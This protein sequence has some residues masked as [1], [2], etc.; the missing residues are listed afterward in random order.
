MDV[1]ILASGGVGVHLWRGVRSRQRVYDVLIVIAKNGS[2]VRDDSHERGD[3][4]DNLLLQTRKAGRNLSL[5]LHRHHSLHETRQ[6]EIRM[7][8]EMQD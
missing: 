7:G 4:V 2:V 3:H 1:E 5:G 8:E 6:P